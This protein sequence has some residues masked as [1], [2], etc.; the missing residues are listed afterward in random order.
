MRARLKCSAVAGT[1]S[2]SG[3]TLIELL[4]VIAIIAIL[5]SL[6]LPAVAKAKERGRRAVCMSNLRQF[7]IGFT[8]Y[9]DDYDDLPE[10]TEFGGSTRHPTSVFVFR[11]D[12]G[13]FLNAEGI[14]KYLPGAF[15]VHD[16]S[17]KKAKVGAVWFCP[18][19][20][21]ISDEHLQN[22]MDGWG[23]FTA[24]YPYFARVEKWKPGQATRPQDLTENELRNDRLLMSD[25]LFHWWY[26]D[27]W[28]FSHGERGPREA[29]R[30]PFE[31]G[32][33]AT[34]AGLN[35]LFGDGHVTWKSGKR[36][37]RQ[38]ISH[39]NPNLG[40]VRGYSS[41]TTFY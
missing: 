29:D 34:L 24:S 4:V 8:L 16:Q 11:G 18:S 32:A 10:T 37:D 23:S 14:G 33:P 19:R 3:F 26:T 9:E 6:L 21:K 39:T 7:G 38:N 28:S 35:Q 30:E 1:R 22:E 41:D 36:M 5:A 27:A 40:M 15:T 2:F 17:N 20:V 12:A 31:K 25:F 13:P